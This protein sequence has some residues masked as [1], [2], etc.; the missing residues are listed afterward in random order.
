MFFPLCGGYCPVRGGRTRRGP[1]C[2][3]ESQSFYN[4]ILE[5]NPEAVP[6]GP[7]RECP[8]CTMPSGLADSPVEESG[9]VFKKYRDSGIQVL[10]KQ[11]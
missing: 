4:I 2:L 1:L 5:E 7:G 9:F 11:D 8:S 6:G 3:I 10:C